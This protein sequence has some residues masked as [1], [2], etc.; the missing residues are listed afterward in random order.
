M[1]APARRAPTIGP[2]RG[3]PLEAA[4]AVAELLAG[5][6]AVNPHRVGKPLQ[7][8]WA[9]HH[10]ARRGEYRVLYAIDEE[11]RVVRV[12]RIGHRRDAYR[13]SGP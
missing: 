4:F 13:A 11:E 5:A 6:L 3:L 2:P 8:V 12:V 10:S 1:E 7:G 9:G